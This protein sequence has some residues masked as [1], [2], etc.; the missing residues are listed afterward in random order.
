MACE[1]NNQLYDEALRKAGDQSREQIAGLDQRIQSLTDQL[2]EAT[3]REAAMRNPP[4][5]WD[6]VMRRRRLAQRLA[7][8]KQRAA[9]MVEYVASRQAHESVRSGFPCTRVPTIDE[10]LA[11]P[12]YEFLN[13]SGFIDELNL[14]S[15]NVRVGPAPE[16]FVLG[17]VSK[18]PWSGPLRSPQPIEGPFETEARADGLKD[19]RTPCV[20]RRGNPASGGHPGGVRPPVSRP[21]AR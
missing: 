17:H 19:G 9:E 11:R 8:V 14:L 1:K 20:A 7:E 12:P 2:R 5:D 3:E 18:G 6:D 15:E 10:S 21:G 16:F 4:V 13:L